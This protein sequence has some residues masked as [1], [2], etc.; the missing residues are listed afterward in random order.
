MVR[1]NSKGEFNVPYGRYKNLNTSLVTES[2]HQLLKNTEIYNL[3][4]KKILIWQTKMILC[5]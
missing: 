4:Y 5:F 2:H 3:D 1:Y